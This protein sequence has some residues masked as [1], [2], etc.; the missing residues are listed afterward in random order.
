MRPDVVVGATFPDFELS[1]HLGRTRRLSTLQ[2]PDPLVLLLSRG[3]FCPKDH[4]QHRNLVALWP[5]F[6]LGYARL[7]TITTDGLREANEFRE[8]VGAT[9]PF[10][11]DPERVVQRDLDI[12]EYTDPVHDPMIPHTFVLAPGLRIHSIYNGYWFWG[13][14]T[15]DDLRRDLREVTRAIRPDWDL[16]A[17]GLRARWDAGDRSGFWPYG[18]PV[19]EL[20]AERADAASDV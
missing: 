16:A 7:V 18:R 6:R 1:D 5:E 14:P 19:S 2:G 3:M 8:Q 17:P 13:R 15:N 4:R 12:A 9:W 20:I 10:L 11:C